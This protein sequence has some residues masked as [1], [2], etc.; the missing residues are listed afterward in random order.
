MGWEGAEYERSSR[1]DSVVWGIV[2]KILGHLILVNTLKGTCSQPV[3]QGMGLSEDSDSNPKWMHAAS[4]ADASHVIVFFT[5]I[6]VICGAP[7]I[8]YLLFEGLTYIVC[9]LRRETDI[10]L[11]GGRPPRYR[12]AIFSIK[13]GQRQSLSAQA[14]PLCHLSQLSQPAIGALNNALGAAVINET[15]PADDSMQPAEDAGEVS[16]LYFVLCETIN[17]LH[18]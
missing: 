4:D 6:S 7:I 16:S 1:Y 14:A 9:G 5:A 2:I 17:P 13:V 10:S 3:L 8:F 12:R 18:C 11:K 15:A